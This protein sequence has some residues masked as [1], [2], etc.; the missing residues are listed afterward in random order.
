[1]SQKISASALGQSEVT[2]KT[3][4]TGDRAGEGQFEAAT[5]Q[6]Q[7]N[8]PTSTAFKILNRKHENK[9]LQLTDYQLNYKE[10]CEANQIQ[11]LD[12]IQELV[13]EHVSYG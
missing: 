11:P 10:Q 12:V 1:M 13:A 6:A 5:P 7:P 4:G 3:M 8:R 2:A 9:S